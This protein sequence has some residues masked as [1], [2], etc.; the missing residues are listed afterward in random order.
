M[1]TVSGLRTRRYHGLLVVSGRQP[2]V[3]QVALAALDPVVEIDGTPVRLGVHEWASGAVSP[4]GHTYLESFTVRNGLPR[5]RWRIGGVVLERELAMV[6]GRPAV[7]VVHR[8]ISG[9]PVRLALEVLAT[10]RDA[11]GERYDSGEPLD[12]TPTADGVVIENAYRVA[13]RGFEPAGQWYT[14][15]RLREERER[16]L[17]DREDLWYAGRFVADLAAGEHLPV[18]AWAGDLATAPPPAE[19]V[20]VDA[21]RRSAEVITAAKPA[22]ETDA[23][24][25]IA[26]DAFVVS[27][28]DVV[29]GYPWF[30]AWSRD[31]MTAYE[32]LFLIAGRADEG[33]AL[34]RRYGSAVSEGMLPNTTDFGAEYNSVDAPLWFVHAVGRHA[35]VT[36]DSGLAADLLPGLLNIV[37][38]YFLG[39]R[40]GIHVKEGI[41]VAGHPDRAL[42]WMDAIVDGTPV[43]PRLGA[44]VEVNA[45]W[46]NALGTLAEL[47]GEP[48]MRARHDTAIAA[49]RRVFSPSVHMGLSDVDG[50]EMALRPNQLLAYSLPFGPL[51]GQP[52]APAIDRALLTPLGLRTLAPDASGYTGRIRGGPATRDRAY[53]QG[54]VWPWLIG[55]YAE[56]RRAA[57]L[58]VDGLLDGLVAHLPEY[59]VG[60]VSEVADGDAPHHAAGCPFQAWSV[61]ELWRARRLL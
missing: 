25:A 45:L 37:D 61:A 1:G 3:R 36:G 44:P 49:F 47:T 41:V 30:G 50:D 54:T 27:G 2:G 12:M 55:P 59:G 24:L 10:W 58:P 15:V 60:S 29:A 33:A 31:T 28:P 43:T 53:H 51:R 26:A 4:D 5:W 40:Y 16:G 23:A 34:L 20:I 39:T 7:A 18:T 11:H 21:T 13:G 38:S 32:G 22:D 8:L 17:P 48:V 56:A 35:A 19:R 6:T 57:G 14:G 46:V 9:G 42:T 52:P